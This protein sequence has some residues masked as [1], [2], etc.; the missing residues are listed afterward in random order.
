MN[1]APQLF[2]SAHGRICAGPHSCFYCG[3]QCDETHGTKEYVSDTFTDWGIVANPIG[4][5]VCEGCVLAMD[6][7]AAMPGRDKPQKIR[8][9]SWVIYENIA[10]PFTK[11]ELEA[12][13][14]ECVRMTADVRSIVIAASGQ[15]HLI[16]R[17]PV[18][19]QA[20]TTIVQFELEQVVYRSGELRT[21]LSLAA[22]LIAATG[23]P[24]LQGEPNI[25]LPIKAAEYWR[26][27]AR[28]AADWNRVHSEPLSRLALYLSPGME[29]CQ[30]AYPSDRVA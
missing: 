23:K 17:A 7:K 1:T 24:A 11:G 16:F 13:R 6:E 12:L 20:E 28:L 25:S 21:R 14:N 5:F 15:K 10:T 4:Q 8:T 22:R 29:D 3:A 18:N 9:Y 27:G 19:R 2:A 30:L 26:H